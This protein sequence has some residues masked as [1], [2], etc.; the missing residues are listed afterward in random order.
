MEGGGSPSREPKGGIC[1]ALDWE[2]AC[3]AVLGVADEPGAGC[4]RRGGGGSGDVIRVGGSAESGNV[5]G[6]ALDAGAAWP[7]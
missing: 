3:G 5:D 7:A 6:R 2:K 1:A 4:E